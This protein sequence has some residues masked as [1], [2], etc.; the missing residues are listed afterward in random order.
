MFGGEGEIDMGAGRTKGASLYSLPPPVAAAT[1]SRVASSAS[2]VSLLAANPLRKG[3]AIYNESTAVLY[4]HLA[5]SAATAT[6]YWLPM[7]ANSY[8]K[9]PFRYVGEIRGI[10]AA[11]NGFAMVS[12]FV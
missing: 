12:E 5:A 10:W 6:N 3:V 8:A 9:L 2:S 1:L 4:V 11:A 7:A